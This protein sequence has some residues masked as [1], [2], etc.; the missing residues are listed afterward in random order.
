MKRVLIVVMCLVMVLGCA[1]EKK[2]EFLPD[3]FV[4]TTDYQTGSF[5]LLKMESGIPWVG[6]APFPIHN[7]AVARFY[8]GFVYIINRWGADSVTLIDAKGDF[9]SPVTE[10]SVGIETNPQDIAVLK[11][12]AYISRLQAKSLLI[13]NPRNGDKLG[14]I[15]LSEFAD[16]DGFPE[17]AGMALIDDKLY[18]VLQLLNTQEPWWPPSGKGKLLEIDTNEDKVINQYELNGENPW[19]LSDSLKVYDGEIYIIEHGSS[20]DTKDGIVEKFN[21]EMKEFKLVITEEELGGDISDIEIFSK[22]IGYA[23]ISEEDWDTA[24]VKFNPESGKKTKVLY[25]PGGYSVAD[26]EIFEDMLL[27]AN[28]DPESSGIVLISIRDDAV[29]TETPIELSLPP[30]DIQVL[31]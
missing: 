13:V 16:E 19:S 18:V 1:E 11:N 9:S 25:S 20:F 4:V 17:M 2:E 30:F 31:R 5:S 26:I 15:D 23:V 6:N 3:V 27:V 7:D 12:K 22:E 29:L 14:E 28:R 21:P 8:D 10:Y 24:V